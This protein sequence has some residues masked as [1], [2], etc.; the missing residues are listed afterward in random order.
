MKVIFVQIQHY[1]GN[2]EGAINDSI[3]DR[4]ITNPISE[5]LTVFTTFVYVLCAMM[6]LLGA[7]KIYQ[8][9]MLG[10]EDVKS[11]MFRWGAAIVAVLVVGT[12][13]QRIASNQKA[14][15]GDSN[16]QNFISE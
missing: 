14:F 8:K 9:Q 10:E 1:V 4:Y 15:Q 5:N 2:G 11:D 12:L 13:I 16:V 3:L 6:A 7:F